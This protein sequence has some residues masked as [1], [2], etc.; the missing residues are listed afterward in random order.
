MADIDYSQLLKDMLAAMKQSFTNDWNDA[1]PY[2]KAELN[3]FVDNIKLI[4]RLKSDGKI[5]EEKAKL[6]LEMQKGSMRIVLLTIDGLTIL[7]VENAINAALD[8]VRNTV[9][10]AIGWTIL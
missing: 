6:Y 4:N 5:T 7:A 9:N 10:T 8:V 3:S 2:A 1:Q